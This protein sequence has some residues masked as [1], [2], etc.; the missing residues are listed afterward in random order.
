MARI[1]NQ[2]AYSL[3]NCQGGTAVDLSGDDNHSIIGYHPHDGPNQAW[4]FQQDGDQ[5]G[6]YIKSLRS[7]QY[8]GIEGSAYS[9][10]VV[11]VA[12]SYPFKWDV[13]D[14]D[15]EGV[16]GIR[17]LAHG[18]NYSLDLSGHGNPANYTKVQLWGSWAGAN[19]IWGLIE[20]P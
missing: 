16:H 2:R 12:V 1:Q 19:Q 6:W 10:G 20:R 8:L 5:N 3:K 13:R 17:I 7:G 9:S 18:T 14:S 4:I 11:A 15:I